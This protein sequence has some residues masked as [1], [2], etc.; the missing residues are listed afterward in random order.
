[1]REELRSETVVQQPEA[2]S[3]FARQGAAHCT[4]AAPQSTHDAV[5][6]QVVVPQRTIPDGAPVNHDTST[7][8]PM[9]GA[10]VIS[11]HTG[12]PTP[13]R[14]HGLPNGQDAA[15]RQSLA[16]RHT[17]RWSAVH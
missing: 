8:T 3:P 11:A 15:Q 1:M 17:R 7:Q 13:A 10:S 14:V 2:Q 9:P 12:D 4:P 16:A 5:A 6:G